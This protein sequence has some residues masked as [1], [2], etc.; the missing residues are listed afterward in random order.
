M[1]HE[2]MHEE[3]NQIHKIGRE[4]EKLGLNVVDTNVYR[5]DIIDEYID[6]GVMGDPTRYKIPTR[7]RDSLGCKWTVEMDKNQAVKLVQLDG[8]MTYLQK[9]IRYT[10]Q[11]Y[12]A[13]AKNLANL[14]SKVTDL[15]VVLHSNPEIRE[16]WDQL[17]VLMKMAGLKEPIA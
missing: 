2:I 4:L 12:E 15:K 14:E 1:Q 10:S 5:E 7:A 16:Q 8:N 11:Q 3:Y 13:C 6:Y 9:E 17:M